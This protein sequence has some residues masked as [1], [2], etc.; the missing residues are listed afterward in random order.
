MSV[1]S[2]PTSAA[3]AALVQQ[4]PNVAGNGVAAEQIETA[5]LNHRIEHAADS[6]PAV[7][8]AR[9]TGHQGNNVNISV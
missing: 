1:G 6:T 3:S 4:I 9:T 5:I 7:E 2:I 8:S